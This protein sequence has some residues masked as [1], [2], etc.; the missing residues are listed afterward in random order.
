M[1][2]NEWL[3]PREF[4]ECIGRSD[5]TVIARIRRGDFDED[6]IRIG[7]EGSRPRYLVSA[8]AIPSGHTR[9][10]GGSSQPAEADPS[11]TTPPDVS[12]IALLRDELAS[13]RRELAEAL[14]E[15]DRLRA[16]VA[17]LRDVGLHLTRATEAFLLPDTLND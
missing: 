2:T 5:Q 12:E 11:M 14:A 10:E 7:P 8:R 15:R 13:A 9:E 16:E 4:G 1:S 3:T 6:C 17:K